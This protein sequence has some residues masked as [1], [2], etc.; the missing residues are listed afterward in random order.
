MT[1]LIRPSSLT[2]PSTQALAAQGVDIRVGD[3]TDGVEKLTEVLAGVDIV[4][5]CIAP[6]LVHL[7]AD[8]FTAAKA[9]GTVKRVVPCDFASAGAPGV[10]ALH[11][12]VGTS[13][14]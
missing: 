11:D 10:R 12:M 1:A 5:S 3:I 14:P 8:L 7:Q 6:W 4:I 13:P 9:A 2:K